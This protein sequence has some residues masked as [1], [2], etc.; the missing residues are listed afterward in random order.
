VTSKRRQH[1]ADELL[2]KI[3]KCAFWTFAQ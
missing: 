1:W 2:V 3:G